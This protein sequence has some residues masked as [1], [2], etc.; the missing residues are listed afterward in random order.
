MPH[1]ISKNI[2]TQAHLVGKGIFTS[3]MASLPFGHT[4]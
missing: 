1:M 3:E 2:A 4:I